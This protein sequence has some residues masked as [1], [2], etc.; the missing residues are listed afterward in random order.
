MNTRGNFSDFFFETMLPAMDAKIDEGRQ[1][2]TPMYNQILREISTDRSIKQFSGVT[3][4][5]LLR[6]VTEG[7]D[8]DTDT[9]LQMFD[10]TFRPVKYGLG[11]AASAELVEDDKFDVI[12][13]RSVALGISESQTVEV[14]AAGILNNG[15]D[16][17]NYPGPDAKALF[18]ATHPLVKAGGSQSNLLS[19]AADLD[20]T[21]LEL[22]LTD[23]E[24]QKTPEGFFQT[25]PNPRLLVA[26]ANRWNATEILKSPMRSDTTNNTTN[27]FKF[28]ENGGIPELMVWAQ[29]SDPDAWFLLAPPSQTNLIWLWRKKPYTRSDYFEKNEVGTVYR[30]Y[31]AIPGFYGFKGTYGTPG[32]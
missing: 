6:A 13:D 25:W 11:V 5:G 19:V 24:T 21:S 31:R 9:I 27:A 7:G 8:T 2:K 32:A 1:M 15:F 29:L 3:G 12:T 18:S 22:A 26:P 20:V 10:S 23:W 14:Q 28:T 30:R 4:V 16:A 17:T